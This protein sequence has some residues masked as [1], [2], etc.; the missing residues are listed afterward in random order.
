M[1]WTS[2][3]P[4]V[5]SNTHTEHSVCVFLKAI[6]S[7]NKILIIYFINGKRRY[8]RKELQHAL[9]T[10]L[11]CLFLLSNFFYHSNHSLHTFET[12]WNIK[13]SV[14]LFLDR[15]HVPHIAHLFVRNTNCILTLFTPLL[16]MKYANQKQRGKKRYRILISITFCSVAQL[17]G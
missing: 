9:I 10:S 1:K 17:A 13:G 5:D 6:Q 2:K 4:L 15:A 8:F 16:P 3:R 12:K 14:G 11:F 7:I